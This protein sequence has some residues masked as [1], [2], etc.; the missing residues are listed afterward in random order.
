MLEGSQATLAQS[1]LC[2]LEINVFN[3]LRGRIT[4]DQMWRTMADRGFTL[5]DMAGASYAP[6]G[7]LRTMDLV[8]ARAEGEVFS[9][10]FEQSRKGADVLERRA[11]QQRLALK[12]NGAI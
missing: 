11:E 2:I 8:F 1:E 9:R 5:I 10:L 7:V 3:R 4:P 6:T 12:N